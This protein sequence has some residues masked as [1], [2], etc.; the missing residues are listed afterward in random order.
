MK[1]ALRGEQS[2]WAHE[3]EMGACQEPGVN[4]TTQETRVWRYYWKLHWWREK[5]KPWGPHG[6]CSGRAHCHS[7]REE[8]SNFHQVN[9]CIIKNVLILFHSGIKWHPKNH[10]SEVI[11]NGNIE[12]SPALAAVANTRKSQEDFR[13]HKVDKS[14]ASFWAYVLFYFFLTTGVCACFRQNKFHEICLEIKQY[15]NLKY[16]R[17]GH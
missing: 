5:T 9:C 1:A 10:C 6:K 17:V 15:N 4:T 11:Q 13:S 3:E 14:N 8:K 12:L 2:L 7:G 16:L